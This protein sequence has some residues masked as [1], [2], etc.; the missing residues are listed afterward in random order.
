MNLSKIA[1]LV[2]NYDAITDEQKAKVVQ[3]VD[4]IKTAI[5]SQPKSN[6]WKLRAKIGDK[7]KWYKEVEEV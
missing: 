6:G 7:I 1:Q 3:Q 2:H 4:T 5:D